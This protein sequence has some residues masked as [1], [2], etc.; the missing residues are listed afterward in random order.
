MSHFAHVALVRPLRRTWFSVR[1]FFFFFSFFSFSFGCRL[2]SYSIWDHFFVC[3]RVVLAYIIIFAVVRFSFSCC[4]WPNDDLWC[5]LNF[6]SL[7]NVV[8]CRRAFFLVF[9]WFD[10]RVR[11]I[12]HILYF[13]VSFAFLFGK[14]KSEQE[15]NRWTKRRI[16]FDSI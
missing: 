1:Q 2:L 15:T 11:L 3:C 5:S 9:M 6:N 16:A 12:F 4:Q 7:C 14:V 13:F 10:F 8:G